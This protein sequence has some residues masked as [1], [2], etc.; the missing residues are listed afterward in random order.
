MAINLVMG[1]IKIILETLSEQYDTISKHQE[2]IPQIELDIIMAN[3]RK[4]YERFY[5]LNNLNS[6]FAVT[7]PSEVVQKQVEKQEKESEI[8]IGTLIE[9]V[10]PEIKDNA[11]EPFDNKMKKD[12]FEEIKIVQKEEK[13]VTAEPPK[14]IKTEKAKTADLFSS[15][16]KEII[17]DKFK[18]SPKSVHEKISVEK[19]GKSTIPSLKS[20]IGIND[21]FLFI[22]NL[23][24][25]DLHDYNKAID[26]LNACD[27][28]ELA[29]GILEDLRTTH[30]WENG[31]ETYQKL[32][33]IV[34]RKFL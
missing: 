2:K 32:E 27:S 6:K 17:A 15:N 34:I 29:T 8:I 24:K 4:L 30:N 11:P 3:I 1:E 26:K 9:E 20:A 31:D 28:I 13:P 16:D 14:K 25:G 10:V 23:F 22:N 18:E 19:I 21:K 5:D 33:D 12:L 7:P